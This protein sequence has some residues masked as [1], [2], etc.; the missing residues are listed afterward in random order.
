[1]NMHLN[2]KKYFFTLMMLSLGLVINAQKSN[3]STLLTT[4]VTTGVLDSGLGFH[5]GINPSYA[6]TSN[7]SIEGQVSYL[8]LKTNSSFIAGNTISSNAVNALAGARLYLNSAE[9]TKRFY[10]NLLLGANYNQEESNSV[11]R[12]GEFDTG[13]SA[14]A[15]LELNKFVIGISYDTPQNAVFKLGLR[16]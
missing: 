4:G 13:L 3:Y 7:L 12:D 5:L 10:I 14:G 9:S 15:F 11:E 2:L 1:M 8:Y 16:F 6:V